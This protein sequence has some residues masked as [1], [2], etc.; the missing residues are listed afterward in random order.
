[1]GIFNPS[2]SGTGSNG[3]V[4]INYFTNP[5]FE[6]GTTGGWTRF[7]TA[8]LPTE[9]ST[10]TISASSS[11]NTSLAV[12][13]SAPLRGTTSLLYTFGIGGS[14]TTPQYQGFISPVLTLDPEDYVQPKILNLSMDYYISNTV[15][16]VEK[17]FRIFVRDVTTGKWQLPL[18]YDQTIRN[19]Y[20]SLQG[21]YI[22][23][24]AGSSQYQV[25]IMA[26]DG[27]SSTIALMRIDN[28]YFGPQ[29]KTAIFNSAVIGEIIPFA[30]SAVPTNF[31]ACDGTAISRST[32]SDLFTVVGT[33]YGVGDGST[34][35]NLPDTRGIF[36]SGA[37]SQTISGITFTRTLGNKQLDTMQGH[38]HDVRVFTAGAAGGVS[39]SGN[40]TAENSTLTGKATTLRDD[41]IN[42]TPRFG[43]ETRP[44]NLGVNYVI[45]YRVEGLVA[46]IADGNVSTGLRYTSSA[47]TAIGTSPTTIPYAT[48]DYDNSGGSYNTSTGIFTVSKSSKLEV[49]AKL[50]TGSITLSTVQNVILSIVKTGAVNRTSTTLVK[51][52]GASTDYSPEV[53]DTFDCVAGDQIKVQCFVS[54]TG[55]TVNGSFPEYNVFN[56]KEVGKPSSFIAPTEKRYATVGLLANQSIPNA[57]TTMLTLNTSVGSIAGFSIS[58]GTV[59]AATS[60][61]YSVS[62]SVGFA[63]NGTGERR[64]LLYKNGVDLI[65]DHQLYPSNAGINITVPLAAKNI[66][67]IA[68]DYFELRVFQGSG[69]ALNVISSNANTF[70]SISQVSA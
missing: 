45:R 60:G 7:Q 25:A 55:T 49:S 29:A 21:I 17:M 11:A 6:D 65:S 67:I 26:V 66:D 15:V 12:D 35:F 41:G 48:V 28:L 27:Y 54:V 4:G 16:Y 50:L 36:L 22:Q 37:G 39:V 57:A 18:N 40:N 63:L 69:G 9:G 47:S 38:N 5:N 51:G 68:G 20:E 24:T 34:T 33:T 42:G 3:S 62:A 52:S 14:G 32:Y 64:L 56:I 44:A 2:T 53:L 13:T 10:T 43:G 31:L 58:A 8:S 30:G 46:S 19:S 23:T 61:R 70:L 1:M 59:V